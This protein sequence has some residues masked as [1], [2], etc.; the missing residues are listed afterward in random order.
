MR[1]V[2]SPMRSLQLWQL[3]LLRPRRMTSARRRGA[4]RREHLHQKSTGRRSRLRADLQRAPDRRRVQRPRTEPPR[5]RLEP[6][7]TA[8]RPARRTQR[9]GLAAACLHGVRPRHLRYR[10]GRDRGRKGQNRC[11]RTRHRIRQ[12]RASYPKNT[13]V[14]RDVEVAFTGDPPL[15]GDLRNGQT[16]DRNS[17]QFPSSCLRAR[18]CA[19]TRHS[20]QCP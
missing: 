3:Q 7:S 17:T 5:G 10:V 4:C 19:S 9:A 15:C 11:W 12:S 8:E 18:C 16:K 13:L 2:C 6:P 20:D 1:A 14:H